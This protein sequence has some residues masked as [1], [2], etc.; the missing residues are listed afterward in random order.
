MRHPDL[1]WSWYI[2]AWRG[3]RKAFESGME[4]APMR[5][6]LRPPNV[7]DAEAL[8]D[9][10][11]AGTPSREA[12]IGYLRTHLRMIENFEWS[13]GTPIR[14]AQEFLARR[15]TL[16]P[17][18][19][20]EITVAALNLGRLEE[21]LVGK[22]PLPSASLPSLSVIAGIATNAAQPA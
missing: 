16:D 22:S 17:E 6:E 8:A 4:S 7:R 1:D 9:A 11:T 14:T 3:N 21:G 13:D 15:D 10:M 19:W 2:P 5:V 20:R 12:E 18:L